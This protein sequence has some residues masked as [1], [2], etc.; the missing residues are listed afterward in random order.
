[1]LFPATTIVEQRLLSV[2]TVSDKVLKWVVGPTVRL[3][4]VSPDS[5]S[6][7]QLDCLSDAMKEAASKL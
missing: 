3:I 1:M 6:K 7:V 5:I 2:V 4:L